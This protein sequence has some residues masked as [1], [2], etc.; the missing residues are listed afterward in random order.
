MNFFYLSFQESIFSF[1]FRRKFFSYKGAKIILCPK[2]FTPPVFPA[3]HDG[4]PKTGIPPPSSPLYLLIASL[5]IAVH[6]LYTAKAG[7]A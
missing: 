5:Y 6:H 4:F 7:S 2:K 1:F 3:D